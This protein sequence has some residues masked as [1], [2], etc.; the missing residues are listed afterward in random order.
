YYALQQLCAPMLV[1]LER[2]APPQR[3]ALATI[4]GLSEGPAP[5]RFTVGLAALTLLAEIAEE[6]PLLCVVDD[7]QWIDQESER[8]FAFIAHRL[9]AERIAIV[10]ATRTGAGDQVL[11]DLPR[12]AVDGLGHGD[13]HALLLEHLHGPMDPSVRERIVVESQGNPL[14]LI[15]LP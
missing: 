6:K 7:T 2:L 13:A 12:L 3:T 9:F 15:E 10:C 1:L 8:V 14:A 11:K 5:D 4:F